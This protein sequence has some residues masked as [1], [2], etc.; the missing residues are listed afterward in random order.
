MTHKTWPCKILVSSYMHPFSAMFVRSS[1]ITSLPQSEAIRLSHPNVKDSRWAPLLEE[2]FF[3]PRSVVSPFR[4]LLFKEEF[5]KSVFCEE[6]ALV[7]SA[8]G[9]TTNLKV[10]FLSWRQPFLERKMSP[11]KIITHHHLFVSI[12]W[13]NYN[14]SWRLISGNAKMLMTPQ[15][16]SFHSEQYSIIGLTNTRHSHLSGT[17]L[18]HPHFP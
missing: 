6:R 16:Q 2:S 15:F 12:S 8:F 9:Y 14:F 18:T 1:P 10:F 5:V 3:L 11:E 17:V 13:F 4:Y 7:L